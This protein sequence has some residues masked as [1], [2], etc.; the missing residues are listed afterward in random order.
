MKKL[1]LPLIL[2]ATQ[3][4]N[5]T[6]CPTELARTSIIQNDFRESSISNLANLYNNNY[7]L[8]NF[9]NGNGQDALFTL[10]YARGIWVGGYDPARNFKF[11]A[12]TYN[13][14]GNSD[15]VS[16][17]VDLEIDG[18]E[19]RCAFFTR[20]W[21]VTKLEVNALR[22][23]LAE[24][25]LTIDKIPEDI[26]LWP[27][28]GNPHI[29][30]LDIDEDMAPFYDHDGNGSY[31][32]MQGD[33]P[34]A[35]QENSDF[36]PHQ[37]RFYIINDV[38]IHRLSFGDALSIEFHVLDYVVACDEVTESEKSVFTR[39]TYI[40]RGREDLLDF[41]LGIWD[42][43]DLG[44]SLDDYAGCSTE[45]N[46]SYVYNARGEDG[47]MLNCPFNESVP[48]TL[49][50]VRSLVLMDS[51]L[52]AFVYYNN[53][54]IGSP[55]PATIQPSVALQYY[56]YMEGLWLD[57]TAMTKGG[58]G[59]NP[60]STDSTK[61]AFTGYP[62]DPTGWSMEQ[63]N[64]AMRD[65]RTVTT[66]VNTN[67]SPEERGTINFIDHVLID[68]ENRGLDIFNIYEEK[69]NEVKQEYLDMTTVCLW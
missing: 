47:N 11:A 68:S 25:N 31:D 44:C 66:A 7:E 54:A 40:N 21:K 10:G 27:A 2:V 34:I 36:L 14:S 26:L 6:P 69:I 38:E 28:K 42:D 1:L 17:P 33:Y 59:F 32:P 8:G 57:G 62:N 22:I 67:L 35:L 64:L 65:I 53:G 5:A 48:S 29:S 13:V 15:Y 43:T 56:N 52:E 3:L 24:G 18:R 41:K 58:D 61:F 4:L 39:L 51:Q 60:G 50:S 16:G 55:T 23:A 49:S 30:V 19:E 37:F 45:L 9:Y 63:E 46:C 20:A 12:S